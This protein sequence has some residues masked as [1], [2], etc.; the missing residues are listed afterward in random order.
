MQAATA[1]H[2]H[3]CIGLPNSRL[4]YPSRYGSTAQFELLLLQSLQANYFGAHACLAGAGSLFALEVLHRQGLQFFEIAVYGIATGTICLVV[5]RGL[6]GMPFGQVWAFPQEF[7]VVDFRHV[8][9][10]APCPP[11]PM[12]TSVSCRQLTKPAAGMLIGAFSAAIAVAFM[13]LHKHLNRLLQKCGLHV[14]PIAS[15][16][17]QQTTHSPLFKEELAHCSSSCQKRIHR[18]G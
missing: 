16:Q 3:R 17:L 1:S 9:V 6:S 8:L 12:V 7:P 11:P 4:L 15:L 5:Y 14:S 10:G 13:Q 2:S 18:P